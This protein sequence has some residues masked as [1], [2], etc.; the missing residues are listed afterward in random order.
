M[1]REEGLDLFNM[2]SLIH[3]N[4]G[5]KDS[6]WVTHSQGLTDICIRICNSHLKSEE[7]NRL[8]I[9]VK[10]LEKY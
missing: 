6:V 1:A 2:P 8:L 5:N 3:S 7:N 9:S 10:I 4:V